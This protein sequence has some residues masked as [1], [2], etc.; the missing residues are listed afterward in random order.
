MQITL[1]KIRTFLK[2]ENY[3]EIHK[4]ETNKN[5]E[6]T[7]LEKR[8]KEIEA[9][10]KKHKWR[11]PL[12]LPQVNSCKLSDLCDVICGADFCTKILCFRLLQRIKL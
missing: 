8:I 4:G 7:Y 5:G 10:H 2:D 1:Y 12:F 3:S 9:L 6:S 11:H